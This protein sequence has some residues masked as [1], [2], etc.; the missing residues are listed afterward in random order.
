M[1]DDNSSWLT[2]IICIA[3]IFFIICGTNACSS[4]DWNEGTCPNCEVRYE[5]RGASKG[6][7]Y[8]ACH[9]CGKEVDRY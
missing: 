7:K 3:L 2:L 4:T 1:R 5:L 8:Y 9:D 6:L